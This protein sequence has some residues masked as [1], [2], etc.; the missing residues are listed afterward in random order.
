MPIFME[1]KTRAG[2]RV[3]IDF[4][5]ELFQYGRWFDGEETFYPA[6]WTLQGKY[7]DENTTTDLDLV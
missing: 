6:R 2:S 5:D 7:V 3:V 1:T 4:T